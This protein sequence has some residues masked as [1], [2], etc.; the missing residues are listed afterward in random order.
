MSNSCRVNAAPIPLAPA[1]YHGIYTCEL[2][3]PGGYVAQTVW[4]TD[5]PS[6]YLAPSQFTQYRDL[7]GHTYALPANHEVPVGYK[8]ILLEN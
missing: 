8:P 4:D 3:R 1:V 2:T 6:I 5:G 7:T